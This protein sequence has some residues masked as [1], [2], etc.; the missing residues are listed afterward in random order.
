MSLQNSLTN[1]ATRLAT[2]TNNLRNQMGALASLS[3]SDK[4]S[5]VAAINELK[6]LIDTATGINDTATALSST[7]SSTKIN[8]EIIAARDALVNGA[9]GALDTLSELAT[10]LASNDGDIATILTAQAKRV[11]TDTASQG[12][13]PAEQA[14]ARTNIDAVAKTDI[15][16]PDIDLIAVFEAGLA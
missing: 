1:F 12:L 9:P 3:T 13:L 7:W 6:G 8:A 2:E 10:A 14:N 11:R 5:L 4:A 15:G 16:N